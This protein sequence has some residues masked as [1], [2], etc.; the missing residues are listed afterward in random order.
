MGRVLMLVFFAVLLVSFASA[1]IVLTQQP[2][3]MYNLGD[4]ISFPIKI[5]SLEDINEAF[6][7][8][9]ICNG[10]E[11]LVYFENII[12]SSG[13]EIKRDIAVPMKKDFLGRST[14]T[15][16]IR[17]VLGDEIKLTNAFKISD[18][19]KIVLKSE[20]KEFVPGEEI[21]IEFEAT[22]ENAKMV[23]GFVN[24]TIG[25][26]NQTKG[27]ELFDVV[28]N[29]YGYIT[30]SMPK[31]T[32]AD[33]Y[34]VKMSV[35]E[36]NL[37]GEIT[38]YGFSN[39]NIKILQV[40][41]RLE[42][43]LGNETIEPGTAVTMKTFLY[44]QTGEKIVAT[45]IITVKNKAG[46][47]VDS[48]EKDTGEDFEFSTL[49][50][51]PPEEFDIEALSNGLTAEASFEI[52]EKADVEV[53]IINKTLEITNV[54]N[55]PYND[56]VVVKI[57]NVTLNLNVSLGLG[58]AVKYVLTAPDG[59][60]M[61][62]IIEKNGESFVTENV[63]LTGKSI[64]I[65]DSAA[66]VGKLI[67]HP[68]SWIF[69]IAVLGFVSFIVFKRGYNKKFFAYITRKK[70]QA[71]PMIPLKKDSLV[72]TKNKA[73]LSLSI[74]GEKQNID[75]V[76]LKVNNLNDLESK[77]DQAE[78]TVQK[79]IDLAEENKA[80]VYQNVNSIFFLFVPSITR[81]FKNEE[82]VI[83]FAQ[84]VKEILDDHNRLFKQ[85]IDFGLALNYGAIVAKQEK[86]ILKFMSLG[87]LITI[88]K[89]IASVS[90]KKVLLGE[91]IKERL[92]SNVK[93]E[94]HGGGDS[95]IYTIKE[96]KN[97]DEHK[98]FIKTFLEKIEGKG[99]DKNSK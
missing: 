16:K 41:T 14:G 9:L 59:E 8:D 86:G 64:G 19:I 15:C 45:S 98:K 38:N 79:I 80:Y 91:K 70:E 94:K 69:I 17:A 96:I 6:R 74:K 75:L 53:V 34:L 67:R 42:L 57:E 33:Q 7:M 55:V 44:D 3:D 99:Q 39:Y 43:V 46:I 20:E 92:P 65:K 56:S 25:G 36:K 23:E 11:T 68:I 26:S 18:K 88:A 78:E 30:F 28:N 84:Q 82:K 85:K 77:K 76:C 61:V 21:A 27:I 13:E 52:V 51:Q 37:K 22:K 60:Y 89:Q 72:K 48:V 4:K 29:G 5:T 32:K 10:Q 35:F 1:E 83:K 97:R 24:I 2:V 49:R 62:E 31:E 87:T 54:G 12:L 81:T 93:V 58:E 95:K 50:N 71:K 47:M 40:P 63:A 66:G 90:D 73:E